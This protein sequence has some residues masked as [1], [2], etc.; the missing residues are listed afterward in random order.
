MLRA[1]PAYVTY[2]C[3]VRVNVNLRA[4]ESTEPDDSLVFLSR[5][6]VREALSSWKLL[7]EFSDESAQIALLAIAITS[8]LAAAHLIVRETK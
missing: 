4:A 2:N 8:N 1:I 6:I 5:M 7:S 3:R